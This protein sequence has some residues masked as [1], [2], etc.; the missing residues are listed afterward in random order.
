MEIQW[1][2]KNFDKLS[3]VELYNILKLRIDVFVLE[4]QCIYL[5]LDDMDQSAMHL[6]AVQQDQLVAYARIQIN[7]LKASAVIRRVVVHKDFRK[8][9]LGNTLMLKALDYI[10]SLKNITHIALSAQFHLKNFYEA[11]GFHA[12]G[13]PYLDTEI[14]H[15]K[16]C[17]DLDSLPRE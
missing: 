2:I 7:E 12:E 3:N 11:L 1:F 4:Q 5:D 13:E 8:M 15:I 6:F 14:L 16:M 17:L 10:D 9:R